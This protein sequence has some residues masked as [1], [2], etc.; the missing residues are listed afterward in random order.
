M[1][2]F[3][4]N[5]VYYNT[6]GI[7]SGA[8]LFLVLEYISDPSIISLKNKLLDYQQTIILWSFDKVVSLKMLYNNNILYIKDLL[9]SKEPVFIYD[10]NNNYN[11]VKNKVDYND[12]YYIL[13]TNVETKGSC[14]LLLKA[15]DNKEKEFKLVK[16]YIQI[17]LHI[18]NDILD[19]N[20][21]FKHF[22]IV[23]NIVNKDMIYVLMKEYLNINISKKYKLF[24]LM[25]NFDRLV[26]DETEE[27]LITEESYE[28][29]Y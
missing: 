20:E 3:L 9:D 21:H 10:K 8:T 1:F 13:N 23:G 18:D 25:N 7:F 5:L 24:I 19:I 2:N 29:I 16:H 14:H 4:Y 26:L 28:K 15:P 12:N 22:S 6:I 27:L 17:E 11:R